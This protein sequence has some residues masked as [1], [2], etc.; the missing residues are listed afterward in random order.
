[1]KCF[2]HVDNDGKCSAAILK[3]YLDKSIEQ[4]A[5]RSM[6]YLHIQD[7]CSFI[8]IDYKDKF[9]I[10]S[11]GP[12]ED[13][14]ILDFS[15]K[16]EEMEELIRSS[17]YMQRK[18][19][20]IDH[21]IT[22]INKYENFEIKINGRNKL[23]T[24][25]DIGGYREDGISGCELTWKFFFSQKTTPL[26]VKL[27]GDRDVWN[28]KY[29]HETSYAHY[30]LLSVDTSPESEM[31]NKLLDPKLDIVD[32]HWLFEKGKTIKSFNEINNEKFKEGWSFESNFE[33]HNC[34]CM[35]LPMCG[36]EAFGENNY[37]IMI[38]FGFNGNNFQISLYSTKV[39]VGEIAK[40]YGGG[41]HVK[42]AGFICKE[43]PFKPKH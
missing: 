26:I 20:W 32:L 16:P 43:L 23:I 22:T 29:G 2:Y 4:T 17:N 37:D 19:I 15:I 14:V 36:S 34:I 13:V 27:I 3:K 25:K 33:G 8:P 28:W 40:K 6:P 38:G 10:E 11:I 30:G 39:N 21:H 35:N 18:I 41:G 42:A 1:M 12:Y 31:W 24:A 7:R 9:P 5:I